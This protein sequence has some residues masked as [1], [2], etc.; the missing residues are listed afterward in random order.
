MSATAEG[1]KLAKYFEVP[2]YGKLQPAPIMNIDAPREYS[3]DVYYLEALS[4]LGEVNFCQ[5]FI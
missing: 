2:V 3:I 4:H 1:T 5:Y